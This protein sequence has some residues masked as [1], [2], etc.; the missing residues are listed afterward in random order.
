MK[1]GHIGVDTGA[2]PGLAGN[3]KAKAS[4]ADISTP[5]A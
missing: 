1:T 2:V 5:T 3:G 4:L